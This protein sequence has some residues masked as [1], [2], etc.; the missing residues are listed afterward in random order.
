M[1]E[2]LYNN[3]MVL[4]IYL[5]LMMDGILLE[6]LYKQDYEMQSLVFF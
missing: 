1:F 3:Q 5:S 2:N 4:D 6:I